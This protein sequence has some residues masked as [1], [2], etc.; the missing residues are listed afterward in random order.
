MEVADDLVVCRKC[1]TAG[2][3]ESG[4]RWFYPSGDWCVTVTLPDIG[5]TLYLPIEDL[6]IYIRNLIGEQKSGKPTDSRT[7]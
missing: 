4:S 7:K 1:G 3:H 2:S 6:P 5:E